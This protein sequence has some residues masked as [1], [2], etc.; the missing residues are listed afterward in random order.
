MSVIK[1]LPFFFFLHSPWGAVH[2]QWW[3]NAPCWWQVG[4]TPWH[5]GS[6]D[7]VHVLGQRPRGVE[8]RCLFTAARSDRR[9]AQSLWDCFQMLSHCSSLRPPNRR[10]ELLILCYPSSV[11]RPVHRWWHLL[12]SKP[13]I[14]QAPRRGLHDELHLLRTG[15]RALEVRCCRCVARFIRWAGI[16]ALARTSDLQRFPSNDVAC[17]L[18]Q[19]SARNRKPGLTTK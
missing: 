17:F 9:Q 19:I 2:H 15:T 18:Q 13:G 16:G 6:H 14:F 7:A 12:W 8:L 4:Q 10:G 1:H 11:S 3:G 5:Y